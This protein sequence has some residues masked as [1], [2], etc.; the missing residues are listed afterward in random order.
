MSAGGNQRQDSI[1]RDPKSKPEGQ[2]P[3]P[4]VPASKNTAQTSPSSESVE[5]QNA[6]KACAARDGRLRARDSET[7]A[8]GV[9]V[10]KHRSGPSLVSKGRNDKAPKISCARDRPKR[11][12][13]IE[14]PKGK[15]RNNPASGFRKAAGQGLGEPTEGCIAKEAPSLT[16]VPLGLE[17]EIDQ[18]VH[19]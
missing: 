13:L 3:A 8:K 2:T 9:S 17:G 6:P 1:L 10:R 15:R 11:T 12:F 14:I 7:R 18:G 5:R 4:K 19:S 16:D